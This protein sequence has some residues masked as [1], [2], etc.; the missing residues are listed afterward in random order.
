MNHSLHQAAGGSITGRTVCRCLGI[1]LVTFS[2]GDLGSASSL[3]IMIGHDVFSSVA[4]GFQDQDR[5]WSDFR[6][7][8]K[9]LALASVEWVP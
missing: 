1:T 8:E 7:E 6:V 5:V 2:S 3:I 4:I 9:E